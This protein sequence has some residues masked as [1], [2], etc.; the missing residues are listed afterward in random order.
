[1]SKLKLLMGA[2]ALVAAATGLAAPASAQVTSQVYG[3]GSSLIAP[4]LRQAEDCYGNPLGQFVVKGSS[5]TNPTHQ[6]V[7]PFNYTGVPPQ[8]CATT[9]VDTTFQLNYISTGSGTGIKG[10]FADNPSMFWGDAGHPAATPGLPYPSIDYANAETA[11]QLPNPMTGAA[12][13][14]QAYSNTTS[15]C[16]TSPTTGYSYATPQG[17]CNFAAPGP[18]YGA[19][20]QIP[21]LITPVDVAYDPVYKRVR[22]ADGTV[23][24]YHFHIA[25][26]RA[27]GSGG[28]VLDAATYC[29]IFEGQIT[30]WNQI[31]TS[32]NGGVR[33]AGSG[34]HRDFQRAAG[35]GRPQRRLGHQF[36]VHPP[37]RGR[38]H[39][40][41]HRLFP[42]LHL[43]DQ[44]PAE[45]RDLH[46]HPGTV[47]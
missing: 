20:I 41:G 8:N 29:N 43:D 17:A 47:R 33:P 36:G 14:V 42:R 5:T 19:M 45:Q 21:L 32:L 34:R 7:T 46:R 25:H 31:P 30:D 12:G 10:F 35:D 1:M 9:H 18:L 39:R 37:P 27:D 28:L 44:Q 22:N 23:T 3:G 26:P 11:M 6:S 24:S 38:V 2:S 4:Y 16:V 40:S 15:T 13:D